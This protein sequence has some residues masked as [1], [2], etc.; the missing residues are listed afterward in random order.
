MALELANAPQDGRVGEMSVQ[1]MKF[2]LVNDMAP[3]KPS[4]CT[5]CSRPLER[6]YLHDLS[7]S[8]RYCGVECHARGMAVSELLESVAPTNP[9]ELAIVWP[10]L[11]VDVA[12]ALF[13]SAWRDRGG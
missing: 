1:K 13:D 2:V 8:R 6:G 5:A 7:T 11:S 10:K 9:F 3:R 4:V 12:S